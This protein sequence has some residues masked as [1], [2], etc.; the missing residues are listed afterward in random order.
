MKKILAL[1]MVFALLIPLTACQ[2]EEADEMSYTVWLYTAQDTA[3]YSEYEQNPV[4][5]YLLRDEYA[6]KKIKLEFQVPAAGQ[7][8]NN[9]QTMLAG[10]EFP[11]LLQS[12]V[13]DPAPVMYDNGYILDITDYVK[14]YMPNYWNLIQTTPELKEKVMFD[15]DGEER[16]LSINTLYDQAEYVDFGG[17]CYR[18]DWIVKYGK[19]PSTGEAFAGGYNSDDVD[20]WSDDV[21]FPSWYDGEKKAKALAI[22][23]T[24]DGTEPFFISDWEWMFEIF[25]E[26]QTALGIADGY[27]VSMYYPGYTWAGGLCSCFGEGGMIWYADTENKVQFGG[28]SDSTRAYFT[29]MNN[30]YEKGWLDQSFNERVND[31]YYQIDAASVRQGKIGMWCGVKGDLGGRIDLKDGGNTEGIFVSGCSYPV[32]DIYGTEECKYVAPRVMNLDTSVVGTGYYI[33]DGADKKDLG[34][35][36]AF[37]DTLYSEEGAV[38]RTLGMNKEQL[39]EDGVETDFYKAYDLLDG[40]YTAD[41]NGKYVISDVIKNDSGSLSAAVSLDKLPGLQLVKNVDRGYTQT[42][43]QSLK[44]WIRYDNQG[45]IWGSTAFLNASVDDTDTCQKALTKVLNY[46]EQNAYKYMDGE[47]D[48]SDDGQWNVWCTALKKFNVDNVSE[49]LQKYVD[50]YPIAG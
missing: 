43:E 41:A 13:A 15:I 19:N 3:Y 32:N 36:F 42:L 48:I 4:L 49:I 28:S 2:K 26:A 33:M 34:P 10:G 22:D 5:N 9:Y 8:Q 21:M 18:R 45:R 40:A 27:C 37:L 16:I 35:L 38:L 25:E 14:E 7:A 23:P 44:A 47:K 11:T 46:M 6:G 17:M 29:C 24:W 50:V 1:L 30:W 12:S 31:V 20:D 39:S